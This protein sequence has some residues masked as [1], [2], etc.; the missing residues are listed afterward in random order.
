MIVGG[1]LTDNRITDRRLVVP[2]NRLPLGNRAARPINPHT[3]SDPWDRALGW[4]DPPFGSGEK[5][6]Q[7]SS[8]WVSHFAL[9]AWL[10]GS[11]APWTTLHAGVQ[12]PCVE[13]RDQRV[14]GPGCPNCHC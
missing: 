12:G 3:V 13:K 9:L 14:D 4:G 8:E 2:S 7:E 5:P 10:A 6:A 1:D 11:E